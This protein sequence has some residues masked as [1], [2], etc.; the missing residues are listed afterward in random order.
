MSYD[1]DEIIEP[2]YF[3]DFDDDSFSRYEEISNT[4]WSF[5][6]DYIGLA[7]NEANYLDFPI[8]KRK[9]GLPNKIIAWMNHVFCD[10]P[11][12]IN[13]DIFDVNITTIK[14]YIS[15][16]QQVM[17]HDSFSVPKGE[18][19]ERFFLEGLQDKMREYC[20]EKD[21]NG[22]YIWDKYRLSIKP[23]CWYHKRGQRPNDI[24]LHSG[25]F[26]VDNFPKASLHGYS[27]LINF[28]GSINV[29]WNVCEK[30]KRLR[31]TPENDYRPTYAL[32]LDTCPIKTTQRLPSTVI[33][34]GRIPDGEDAIM[35]RD[36]PEITYT[37]GYYID[38][39]FKVFIKEVDKMIDEARE[40]KVG[41]YYDC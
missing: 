5:I 9:A 19:I 37:G 36:I 14:S 20:N 39:L 34:F 24:C 11:E 3:P 12:S 17:T 26:R 21:E 25:L 22:D 30:N 33:R 38:D 4:K 31:I 29:K 8:V 13:A 40:R 32:V 1:D 7:L 35:L 28:L 41:I 2:H 15:E 27:E 18:A 6:F 23:Y 16:A 10:V